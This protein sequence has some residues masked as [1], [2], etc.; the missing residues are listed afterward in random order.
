MGTT[1]N[2]AYTGSVTAG[3]LTLT[4]SQVTTFGTLKHGEHGTMNFVKRNV[5]KSSVEKSGLTASKFKEYTKLGT[6]TG[7]WELNERSGIGTQVYTDGSR[8][9]G[10]W[11]N[12]L[13]H[14]NGTLYVP[15]NGHTVRQYTG[16]WFEDKPG[17]KGT[18]FYANG[19]K[20]VDT[21]PNS[22]IFLTFL[23]PS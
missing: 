9:E 7:D 22:P 19:D 14:G 13:R 17:G 1:R 20:Y 3:N 18:F 6:Y 10:Q 23:E 15:R 11:K 8:Y 2:P 12:N 4:R 16:E 21:M 5:P